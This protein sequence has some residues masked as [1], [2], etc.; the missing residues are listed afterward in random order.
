[1]H[2][3]SPTLKKIFADTLRRGCADNAPL[4]AWPLACGLKVADKTSAIGYADG[5][6]TVEVPDA[7]WQQQLHGL[8]P[9]YLA[10]LKQICEQPVNAIKFVVR[11]H[12]QWLP[13]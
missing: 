1:M 13:R 7:T 9:Q 2:H 3:A 8:S 12:N 4:L 5:V 10:A 6:L 11:D